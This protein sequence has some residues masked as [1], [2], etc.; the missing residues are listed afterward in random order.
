M[1][2][3]AKTSGAR[4]R[5]ITWQRLCHAGQRLPGVEQG[6]SYRTPALFVRG[7][8]LARLKE[9]GETVVVR[10]EFADRDVLVE[11]DPKSFYVTDHYRAYPLVLMRLASVRE[12][13]A[14][15]LLSQAWRLVAP[16]KQSESGA[17]RSLSQ[18][19]SARNTRRRRP[20]SG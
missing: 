8:L 13:V 3:A 15:E 16:K 10:V 9:D 1:T 14:V 7:K 11:A 20:T 4:R 2:S 5:G 17:A 18:R 19:T 12:G 6:I